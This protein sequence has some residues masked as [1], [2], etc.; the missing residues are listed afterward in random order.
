MVK[1]LKK[2][3]IKELIIAKKLMQNS[4]ELLRIDTLENNLVAISSLN[5]VLNI[6]IKILAEQQKIKSI[7]QLDSESL[8]K[9]WSILSVEY[10]KQFGQKLSMKTQIFTLFGITQ[11]FIEHN[12]IPDNSQINELFQALSFFIQKLTKQLFAVEFNEID[13]HLLIDNLQ[14]RRAL[15]SANTG[16][17]Q[18]KF[19]EVLKNSSLAFHIAFEDQRNKLNF[20]SQEGI[21]KSDL[22]PDMTVRTMKL[23]LDSKDHEFIHLILRTPS[24]KLEQF[25]RIVPTVLISEDEQSGSEIIVSNFVDENVITKENAHF[26]LNFTLGERGPN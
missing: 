7:K 18:G 11:N 16:Y 22:L 5:S 9:Q 21:L 19:E 25:K 3:V 10:E 20:L 26:C 8:E 15:E 14:V 13:F 2:S 4:E 1:K 23:H 6:F 24:K 17:I 12:I